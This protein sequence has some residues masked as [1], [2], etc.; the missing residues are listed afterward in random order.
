MTSTTLKRSLPAVIAL[1]VAA[2]G[3]SS[4]GSSATPTPADVGSGQL[5]GAGSTFNQPFFDRAFF[6]YN[7][8]Y[9]QVTVNYQAVG[10]GAGVQQFIKGTVDFGATDVP[11]GAADLAVAGGA[12]MVVQVPVLLG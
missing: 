12:D 9:T 10:S 1:F 6:A 4:G 2:C 5:Q 8:K 3:G 7:Q 11:M